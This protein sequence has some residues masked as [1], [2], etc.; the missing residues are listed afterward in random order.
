D[1]VSSISFAAAIGVLEEA[2]GNTD[3]VEKIFQLRRLPSH[4]EYIADSESMKEDPIDYPDEPKA[5][6]EDHKEDPSEEHEPEDEDHEEDPS[7]E[8]ELE[9]K[10]HEED[11]SEEH[12]PEDEDTKD[13][14]EPSKGSNETEPFE[15]D[16]TVVTPPPPRHHGGR[17]SAPLGHRAAMIHVGDDIPKEDMPPTERICASAPTWRAE[18]V[19]YVRALQAF[20]HRMITSIEEVNLRVSYQRT[21]YEIE[22][23]KVHQAY[24]SS[25]AWNRALVAC[26][27]TLET[28]MSHMEWQRQDAEDCAVRH[29]I[30]T[31]VLEARARIDT[32]EDTSS[33]S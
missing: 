2:N 30:C 31:H 5:G 28:H 16:K 17:I 20:E 1:Q 29:V 14:E 22:L 23:R 27:E 9:D 13:E 32:V 18:D 21:A 3:M 10:D 19:G 8:H 26:L 12:E 4:R 15:E 25:E 24:L 6:D 7:E 33:S 11:P